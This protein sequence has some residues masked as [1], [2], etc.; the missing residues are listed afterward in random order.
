M[1]QIWNPTSY[2]ENAR[3]VADLGMPVLE[4]VKPKAGERILDL[5]CGDG[6][7]TLKIQAIGC[8]VIGVD[9]SPELIET[10]KSLGLDA[11]WMDGQHLQFQEEF[12][13]VFSNAA[14]HWMKQPD[15]VIQ[16]VWTALKPAG[17]FVGELGGFGNVTAIETA[18]HT[19]LR[20]RGI[21]PDPLNPWYFPTVEDYRSK[22]MANG[23]R[24]NDIQLIPRPTPLPTDIRGWLITFGNPFINAIEISDRSAFLDDVVTMLK[25]MLWKV[26]DQTSD[27]TSGQWIA[28]Y[29]RLRFSATKE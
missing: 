7:L 18:L 2:A 1:G 4:W 10:A 28:D 12:D 19:A 23:F 8:D 22:L 21:D 11:R 14:L 29:V 9:T 24:V 15:A 5:G 6:D 20:Q 26:S 27:E 13:A 17:R 16:G 25:P 3:F